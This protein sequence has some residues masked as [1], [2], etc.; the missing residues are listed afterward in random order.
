MPSIKQ[1]PP[2][3]RVASDDLLPISQGAGTRSTSV[4][5]LLSN[6][7]P[8]IKADPN[9]LLGRTSPSPGGPEPV[10]LGVGL[11]INAGLL[12]A[13]GDDHATFPQVAN[14][15]L[16]D[17]V[18]LNSPVGPRLLPITMLRRLFT[19][20][21]NVTIGAD[22]TLNVSVVAGPIG[23]VGPTGPASTVPGPIGPIGKTGPAGPASTVPGPVGP[24]GAAGPAGPPGPSGGDVGIT[25][26]SLSPALSLQPDDELPLDQRDGTTR[27]SLSQVNQFVRTQSQRIVEVPA[28]TFINRINHIGALIVCTGSGIT[29]LT[30]AFAN[31]GAGFW[32][33]VVNAGTGTVFF[34]SGFTP[35][36]STSLRPKGISLLRAIQTGP[37]GGIVLAGTP[38]AMAAD[39]VMPQPGPRATCVLDGLASLPHAGYSVRRLLKDYNGPALRV[40][41]SLNPGAPVDIGF[42][43]A[44]DLDLVALADAVGTGSGAVDIWYD[45]VGTRNLIQANDA[46]S[47]PRI[48]TNGGPEVHPGTPGRAGLRFFHSGTRNRLY[49][50]NFNVNGNQLATVLVC[51][52]NADPQYARVASYMG[53]GAG[54][55]GDDD[56]A[57]TRSAVLFGFAGYLRDARAVRGNAFAQTDAYPNILGVPVVA[58]TVH[59]GATQRLFLDGTQRAST[60]STTASFG[61][62]SSQFFV[63]AHNADNGNDKAF[64]GY[65]GEVLAWKGLSDADRA[66]VQASTRAYFIGA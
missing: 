18:L 54:R 10:R 30:T 11:R 58:S 61:G 25:V 48:M 45:Q 64:K 23:P 50:P 26:D 34:G 44:G 3:T 17:D 28:T 35:S 66:T 38:A 22:G 63:G 8:A 41:P 49:A 13:T 20:G 32:C 31:L 16:S 42:T 60:S 62:A 27:A 1:L 14:L 37:N 36:G 5:T 19:A 29:T 55:L 24:A 2:A 51:A 52:A 40:V 21:E 53:A 6:T 56:Y 12:A 7:Q 57:D 46:G 9:T 47:L 15:S 43:Q 39:P 4:D 59:D 33:E 65:I